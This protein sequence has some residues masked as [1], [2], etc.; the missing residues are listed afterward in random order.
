MQTLL[1]LVMGVG[2]ET[3]GAQ[4]GPRRAK[5]EDEEAQR[6][7]AMRAIPRRPTQIKTR[8]ADVCFP[9]VLTILI[10]CVYESNQC[11][12]CELGSVCECLN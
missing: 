2:I 4:L 11:N 7:S 5:R 1:G 8:R 10:I 9:G 12:D 6:K 3:G